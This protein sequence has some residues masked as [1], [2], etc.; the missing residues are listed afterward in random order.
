MD[1]SADRTDTKPTRFTLFGARLP[2]VDGNL[3]AT[4]VGR[5]A[6]AVVA[7]V[8]YLGTVL[9]DRRALTGLASTTTDAAANQHV[10]AFFPIRL[11]GL[12]D[13][14]PVAGSH[15]PSV[16]QSLRVRQT[17]VGSPVQTPAWQMSNLVQA[18]PSS[19]SSPSGFTGAEQT[20]S[21]GRRRP[22]GGRIKGFGAGDKDVGLTGATTAPPILPA[23]VIRVAVAREAVVRRE[24]R[25]GFRVAGGALATG[26]RRAFDAG[27]GAVA[28]LAAI[29]PAGVVAR[30]ASLLGHG[31]AADG[32]VATG[33]EAQVV[34]GTDGGNAAGAG[35]GLAG[36]AAGAGVAV[37]AGGAVVGQDLGAD[38]ALA[39]GHEAGIIRCG[40]MVGGEAFDAATDRVGDQV[41]AGRRS[42]RGRRTCPAGGS[43]SC[44]WGRRSTCSRACTLLG[45]CRRSRCRNTPG[46]PGRRPPFRR[47]SRPLPPA[48]RQELL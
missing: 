38:S 33:D 47:R 25:T 6:G 1:A 18:L 13:A 45:R 17:L 11:L 30:R 36:G 9:G 27:P 41:R 42:G 8:G 21:P 12:A 35:T 5:V 34:R 29:A 24:A 46:R 39:G 31:D 22:G 14:A 19:H 4:A 10:G 26:D 23:E 15:S 44:R 37:V 2:I 16:T 48:C 7:C 32:R 28:D 43:G 40:T 3:V 20:P